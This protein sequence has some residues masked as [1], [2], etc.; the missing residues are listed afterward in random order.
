MVE[1]QRMFHFGIC[2]IFHFFCLRRDKIFLKKAYKYSLT[3]YLFY[4]CGIDSQDSF[5][6]SE[7]VK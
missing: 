1:A 6:E 4:S 2:D 7:N 3:A 5:S